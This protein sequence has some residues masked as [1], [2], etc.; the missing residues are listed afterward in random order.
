MR[1]P[2]NASTRVW[3]G[4]GRGTADSEKRGGQQDSAP[5][6]HEE[7]TPHAD[8]RRAVDPVDRPEPRPGIPTGGVAPVFEPS[9][10]PGPGEAPQS[11]AG[12]GRSDRSEAPSSLDE[13]VH[14][15]LGPRLSPEEEFARAKALASPT[16]QPAFERSAYPCPR[17]SKNFLRYSTN[18]QEEG[19]A[20]A[21]DECCRHWQSEDDLL[22]EV[23]RLDEL[24][25]S[26]ASEYL[27]TLRDPDSERSLRRFLRPILSAMI[28]LNAHP[29]VA[30]EIAQAVNQRRPQPVPRHRLEELMVQ[31]AAE[32]AGARGRARR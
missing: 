24:A 31:V 2:R 11:R 10:G 19:W 5:N 8:A 28:D 21:C 29:D 1:P 16:M 17:C 26:S 32:V 30:L 13:L 12:D 3:E 22:H 15:I 14:S 9:G 25:W 4:A 20:V 6:P 7:A 18:P 27:D 23:I